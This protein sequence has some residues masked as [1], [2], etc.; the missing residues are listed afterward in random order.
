VQFEVKGGVTLAREF[1]LLTVD[2][3]IYVVFLHFKKILK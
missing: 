3:F 2:Q 1:H